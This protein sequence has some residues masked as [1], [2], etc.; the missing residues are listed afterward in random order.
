MILHCHHCA[1]LTMHY[2]WIGI[3]LQLQLK[4]RAGPHTLT[5]YYHAVHYSCC[6]CRDSVPPVKH[7]VKYVICC[8]LSNG[9]FLTSHFPGLSPT[10]VR[11]SNQGPP[12]M[13]KHFGLPVFPNLPHEFQRCW[14]N[15][16]RSQKS[17]PGNSRHT[18]VHW[19]ASCFI[20]EVSQNLP[21]IKP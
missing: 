20:Q 11:L 2:I 7:M 1:V 21:S 8:C 12:A 6:S 14:S 3:C 13:G 4:M 17:A 16:A 5:L 9:P 15:S 10:S 18:W 19:Y